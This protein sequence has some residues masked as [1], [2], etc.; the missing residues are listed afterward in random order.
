M[1]WEKNT[2]TPQ[3]VI[4]KSEGQLFTMLPVVSVIRVKVNWCRPGNSLERVVSAN[5][6]INSQVPR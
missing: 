2:K 6:Q 3:G 5:W 1:L 4:L